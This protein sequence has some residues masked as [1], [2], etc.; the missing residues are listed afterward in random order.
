[1]YAHSYGNAIGKFDLGGQSATQ[2]RT[3]M[4]QM[5]DLSARSALHKE[6]PAGSCPRK[7][8]P[9]GVYCD[10]FRW[11]TDRAESQWATRPDCSNSISGLVQK[12]IQEERDRGIL[13]A[14]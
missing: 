11:L 6:S 1:M 12:G 14:T 10:G 9:R 3:K 8:V 5:L 2:G 4:I 13:A 7:S